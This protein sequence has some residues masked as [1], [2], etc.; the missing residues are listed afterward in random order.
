MPPFCQSQQKRARRKLKRFNTPLMPTQSPQ[1]TTAVTSIHYNLNMNRQNVTL[2][3][4][5]NSNVTF[6]RFL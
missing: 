3:Y 5:Q 4:E 1:Y 6:M 2:A